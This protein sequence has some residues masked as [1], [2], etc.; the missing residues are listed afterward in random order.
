M[1]HSYDC[2][3]NFILT[4]INGE[5]NMYIIQ[6]ECTC[7]ITQQTKTKEPIITMP[8]E[9]PLMCNVCMKCYYIHWPFYEISKVKELTKIDKFMLSFGGLSIV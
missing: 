8:N 7:G 4:H 9:L 1:N 6:W 3:E 5:S 2:I